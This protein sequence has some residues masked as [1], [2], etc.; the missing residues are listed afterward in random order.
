MS[1][2]VLFLGNYTKDTIATPEATRTVHG[3][4]FYYGANVACRLG[5]RTAACCSHSPDH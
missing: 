2:D 4:A 1:H 5:L 3:G